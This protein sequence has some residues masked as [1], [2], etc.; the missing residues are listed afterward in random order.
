MVV[1]CKKKKLFTDNK[2]IDEYFFNYNLKLQA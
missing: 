2:I 1:H